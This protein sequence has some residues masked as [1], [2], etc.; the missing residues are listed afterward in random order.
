MKQT[1]NSKIRRP[2]LIPWWQGLSISI[3]LAPIVSQIAELGLD[4]A[5]ITT[6]GSCIGPEDAQYRAALEMETTE[7]AEAKIMMMSDD[8]F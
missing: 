7:K 8:D 5:E 2:M 3:S 6:I 4:K 1:N